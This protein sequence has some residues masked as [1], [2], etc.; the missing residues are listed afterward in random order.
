MNTGVE[1]DKIE[2]RKLELIALRKEL[3]FI[4]SPSSANEFKRK[5]HSFAMRLD[6][7]EMRD[8]LL[9]EMINRTINEATA[10]GE[11][12]NN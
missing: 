7:E 9:N 8:N 1:G 5:V 4:N 6:E 3:N 10:R 11:R 12:G 2:R